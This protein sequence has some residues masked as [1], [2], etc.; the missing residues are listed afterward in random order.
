MSKRIR[1]S[2]S[3]GC[4]WWAVTATAGC[5]KPCWAPVTEA[6]EN[7]QLTVGPLY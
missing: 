5:T 7:T 3:T 2:T 1:T 4:W 6:A